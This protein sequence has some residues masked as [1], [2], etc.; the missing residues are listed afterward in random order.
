MSSFHISHKQACNATKQSS[1]H[2]YSI[3]ILIAV[4]LLWCCIVQ[5]SF[6]SELNQEL[7]THARFD[8][9][10]YSFFQENLL[11]KLRKDRVSHG[12][13]MAYHRR[14]S[15][16]HRY[17]SELRTQQSNKNISVTEMVKY[18]ILFY[19]ERGPLDEGYQLLMRFPFAYKDYDWFL[20][21]RARYF[22]QK[23]NLDIFFALLREIE[24]RPLAL[25]HMHD[26]V[27]WVPFELNEPDVVTLLRKRIWPKLLMGMSEVSE[28]RFFS[29]MTF[30]KPAYF[31]QLLHKDDQLTIPLSVS[32]GSLKTALVLRWHLMR[33]TKAPAQIRTTLQAFEYYLP[34][35]LP[36]LRFKVYQAKHEG[37]VQQYRK[38]LVALKRIDPE[39]YKEIQQKHAVHQFP[40]FKKW[41]SLLAPK[42]SNKSQL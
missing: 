17:E 36:F 28:R 8:L 25:R 23:H 4:S 19:L 33:Y 42:S 10:E 20:V 37:N 27:F 9:K 6:E 14:F 22:L 21:M 1:I 15:S 7:I 13:L 12:L 24:A 34:N 2:V 3:Y 30:M 29:F 31:V 26:W 32:A 18:Q 38:R 39:F 5:A 35:H 41:V 40:D 11:R 16:F